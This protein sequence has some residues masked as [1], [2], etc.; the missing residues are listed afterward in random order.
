M[1]LAVS[2]LATR[3]VSTG[4][5]FR[6]DSFTRS[7]AP[8]SATDAATATFNAACFVG[9]VLVLA[10]GAAGARA[11]LRCINEAARS[12]VDTVAFRRFATPLPF[13]CRTL[14]AIGTTRLLRRVLILVR[15]ASSARRHVGY[16]RVLACTT[17]SACG[18]ASTRTRVCDRACGAVGARCHVR[19]RRVLARGAR[20]TRLRALTD[21][22]VCDRSCLTRQTNRA[23]IVLLVLP[24]HTRT[25]SRCIDRR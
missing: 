10:I 25:A 24:G 8:L 5:A 9:P 22:G 11:V 14:R 7:F 16:R 1:H 19:G 15:L 23:A 21:A 20:R 12:T 18:G 2:A 3:Q 13:S 6:T 4:V 17:F